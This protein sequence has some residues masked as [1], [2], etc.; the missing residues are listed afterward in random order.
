MICKPH[1][2][3]VVSLWPGVQ[4]QRA[5]SGSRERGRSADAGPPSLVFKLDHVAQ[6]ELGEDAESFQT[7]D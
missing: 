6:E 3:T 5:V 4:H 2:V 1:G 7:W